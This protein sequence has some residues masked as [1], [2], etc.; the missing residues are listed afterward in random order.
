MP[1]EFPPSF[2]GA[3]LSWILIFKQ[4]SRC[5]YYLGEMTQKWFLKVIIPD[6]WCGFSK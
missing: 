3:W 2:E 5:S 6:E 4:W 1:P